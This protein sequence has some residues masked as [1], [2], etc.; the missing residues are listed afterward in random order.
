M[1]ISNQL[2]ASTALTQ[3]K[4]LLAPSGREIFLS[5]RGIETQ[6]PSPYTDLKI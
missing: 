5:L 3:G 1:E 2:H 6:P 4:N